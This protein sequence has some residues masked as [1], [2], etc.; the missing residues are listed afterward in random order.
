MNTATLKNGSKKG[1][2]PQLRFS[3]FD[4]EWEVKK[5]GDLCDS[6]VPGRNKPTNFE[7]DIPWITT[8]DIEHNGIINY[9][10]KGLN[11]SRQEAKKVGSKI[12]PINS[13]IISCVGE[14]GLSAI[15]GKEIIINQQ[16][17]AFIPK[18]RIDYRFLLY[19][20]NLK[21]KYMDKVATKTAVPYMNKDNCNSIPIDFPTIPEQHK[22]ASFLSAV[23]EKI[24]QL[25]RKKQLLSQYKKGV[26]QQLFS[27]KLRF[28]DENG[29]DYADWE[30]KFFGDIFTFYTTNSLSREKL[31]YEYGE[32]KNIHYGDIHTK[33]KTLF[34]IKNELIPF[35]NSDFD[36]SKIKK[37]CYCQEGDLV[38]TDAS[39]DYANIGKSIE[40]IN[41]K[42]EKVLAGLHTFLARPNKTR[43]YIGFSG[44]I[45]RSDN[46]R[47]QIMTIA[48]GSKILSISTGRLAMVA[49]KIPSLPEQQKIANFLSGIDGKIEQVNGELV[50]TQEFKKGLLQQM[51]V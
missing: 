14:L 40:I 18:E 1:I 41:L 32:V 44:Y 17:H 2:V 21:K 48:Q 25:S 37:E 36:V 31:N 46:F 11:I 38:I 23:D 3:G 27:G 34:D 9:S 16:L 30:E 28:K 22:I 33:F 42:N 6:I 8:P 43:M 49:M 50:K 39:E 20:L 10:K 45:V 47:K 29:V 51:F 15:A 13:I 19:Q 5:V 26:M 7:G 35:V 12:V 24:Q 4:G